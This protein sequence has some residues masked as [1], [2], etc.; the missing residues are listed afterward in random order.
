[1]ASP[2]PTDGRSATWGSRAVISGSDLQAHPA[3]DAGAQNRKKKGKSRRGLD[4]GACRQ[5]DQRGFVGRLGE[6]TGGTLWGQTCGVGHL[7]MPRPGQ[8]PL[9]TQRLPFI[10]VVS[11]SGVP[12]RCAVRHSVERRASSEQVSR[13]RSAHMTSAG[14][15]R[16]R[17]GRKQRGAPLVSARTLAEGSSPAGAGTRAQGLSRT[18]AGPYLRVSGTPRSHRAA[19]TVFILSLKD[20]F[21]F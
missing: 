1:M 3:G 12:Q 17:G 13:S 10:H 8:G 5:G 21:T 18:L 14:S 4:A 15:Q 6:D 16:P 19:E 11:D 9:A 20:V 2:P 7:L